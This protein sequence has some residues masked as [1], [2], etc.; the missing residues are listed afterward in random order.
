MHKANGSKF[1]TRKWYIVNDQSNAIYDE[2]NEIVHNT[3][4]LKS[5]LCY[6][7]NA[8]ILA[9]G[10]ITIIGQ[11]ATQVAFKNC[12]P[13]TKCITKIERTTM[14]IHNHVITQSDR[15]RFKLLWNNMKFMVLF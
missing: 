15:I 8:Y 1:V 5:N 12:A 11:Q 10:D 9:T 2:G 4:V 13:F 7:N 6:Y 3:E 14:P